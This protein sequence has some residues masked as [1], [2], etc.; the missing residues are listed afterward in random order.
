MKFK[1]GQKVRAVSPC[2]GKKN[3]VGM[4]GEVE[5]YKKNAV[6]IT[7]HHPGYLIRFTGELSSWWCEEWALAPAFD[8]HKFLNDYYE[9]RR[10]GGTGPFR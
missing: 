4:T 2:D 5:K 9:T 7:G 6:F 1:I 8:I 3:Y 10:L